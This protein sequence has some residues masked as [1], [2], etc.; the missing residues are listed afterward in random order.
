MVNEQNSFRNGLRLAVISL[1]G[2]SSRRAV[3]RSSSDGSFLVASLTSD[4]A[5]KL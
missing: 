1:A 5:R 2:Y 4:T 3:D